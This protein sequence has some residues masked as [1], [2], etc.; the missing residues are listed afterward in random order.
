[1]AVTVKE[2]FVSS[3]LCLCEMSKGTWPKMFLEI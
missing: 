2:S 1:M 3:A